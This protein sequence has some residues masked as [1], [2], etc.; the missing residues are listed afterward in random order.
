MHRLQEQGTVRFLGLTESFASDHQ[1]DAL[2]MALADNLFDTLL[3]GYN[4]LTP[5]AEDDVFPQAQAQDVGIMIM[6]AVRRKIGRPADLEILV[7]DLKQQGQLPA[8]VPDPRPFDWLLH[9]D[10]RSVTDAAYKFAAGHPAVA[11]VL[12]GTASLAHLEANIAAINGAPLAAEDR[13]TLK[14]WF[15]PI[16]RKLG[17]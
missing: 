3:V 14:A 13:Q 8:S 16:G 6:C 12:T 11:S 2:K 5:G 15:G 7:R 1:R 4:F 17:D 9:D 10:V